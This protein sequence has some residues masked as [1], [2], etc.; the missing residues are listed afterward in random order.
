M[1]TLPDKVYCDHTPF[2]GVKEQEAAALKAGRSP[3]DIFVEGRGAETFLA[4]VE[5]IRG[6]GTLGLVG[7][8]R[9]FGGSRKLVMEKV[10]VLRERGITPYD[11]QTG[12]DDQA[13]LLH[14]AITKI[15][16]ARAMQNNRHYPKRIG[17]RGGMAKGVAHQ[18][19]RNDQI[20]EEIVKRLCAH[21]NLS[22]GDCALILGK[23]FSESSLRRLYGAT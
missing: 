11:L 8:L 5:A 3:R 2:C 9:V 7:G 19:R 22:W 6:R 20:D 13:E 1:L 17:R 21:P 23:G 10:R 15:A 14:Q 4:C 18:K 12:V 16:G